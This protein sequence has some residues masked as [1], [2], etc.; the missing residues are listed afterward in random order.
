MSEI[1]DEVNKSIAKDIDKQIMKEWNPT[2]FTDS[3][4]N[5]KTLARSVKIMQKEN[6]FLVRVGC[7]EF[8]FTDFTDMMNSLCEY[9]ND[10]N[11]VETDYLTTQKI[12]F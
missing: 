10:V 2:F 5:H 9:Y 11:K 1:Q 3:E 6:G 7:K 8:V 4:S 12:P